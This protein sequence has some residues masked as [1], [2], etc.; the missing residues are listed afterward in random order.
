VAPPLV[1]QLIGF[2]PADNLPDGTRVFLMD[3]ANVRAPAQV[4][5]VIGLPDGVGFVPSAGGEQ[6][7]E[8]GHALVRIAW[9][10]LDCSQSAPTQ[11]FLTLKL[12]LPGG[13]TDQTT[14]AVGVALDSA[15]LTLCAP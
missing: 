13:S 10:T 8:D 15:R 2:G 4:T 14:V 6:V 3:I 7:G 12:L 1:A 5:D 11:R 9:R